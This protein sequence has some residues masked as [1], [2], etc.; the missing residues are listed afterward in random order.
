MK[1]FQIKIPS[2]K[3]LHFQLLKNSTISIVFGRYEKTD[4]IRCRI[5][6]WV[7]DT[8]VLVISL[9]TFLL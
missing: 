9:H 2:V 4:K 3:A 6:L 8:A 1:R 7:V 5:V